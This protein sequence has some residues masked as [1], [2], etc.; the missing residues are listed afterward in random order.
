MKPILILCIPLLILA[1]C[2]ETV[3]STSPRKENI[4]ESVYASGTLKSKNQYQVFSTV[5]GLLARVW[6]DEG[7]TVKRGSPL[8]T[9][10]NEASKLTRE[11]AQLAADLAD[12][13]TNQGK[14]DE[15]KL[16]INL[17]RSRLQND[18]LLMVRQQDL[19]AQNLGSKVEVE[20]AQLNFQNSKTAYAAAQ[21]RYTDEKRRLDIMSK[22]AQ[23]NLQITQSNES[24]FTVTSNINGKI[25]SM[26]KEQGEMV[27]TQTA[28]AIIGDA[29]DFIIEL[30]VDEYDIT[31]I[32]PG[33]Q[34]KISMDSYK[35]QVFDA[36]ITK[37]NPIL[38]ERTKTATVEAVFVNPP[39]ALYPNL[40]LE[41]N[42]IL[43]VKENVLT[44]PRQYILNDQFVINK[45]G[46]TLTIKT[47]VKD[48]LKAEILEGVS[49]QDLLIRPGS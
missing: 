26:L 8:F 16:N 6:V 24:D 18:S 23:K 10:L 48:Y 5:N 28:L 43:Q 35:G 25:Y 31:V 39:P 4:T 22:Q 2:K 29:S 33:Q 12:I 21:L 34:V 19:W 44:L 9:I 38:N 27:N 36:M 30:Q 37:I 7:D 13:R 32:R 14:L 41:A 42:I 3:E 47:G 15:L 20:R 40:S 46:D 49:E 1:G 45:A 17:A 11:N